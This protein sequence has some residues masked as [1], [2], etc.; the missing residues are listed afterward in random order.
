MQQYKAQQDT[1]AN[2]LAQSKLDQEIANN[3][4]VAEARQSESKRLAD[5]AT[6]KAASDRWNALGYVGSE[7]DAAILGIPVGTQTND[8]AYRDSTL[9]AS[10]ARSSGGSGGLSVKDLM[11]FTQDEEAAILARAKADPR[12]ADGVT[13]FADGVNYFTLPQLIDAYSQ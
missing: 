3:K 7:A 13:K 9:A 1:A 10:A 5:Q 12:L 2:T 8:A 11:N 4:S 6:Y